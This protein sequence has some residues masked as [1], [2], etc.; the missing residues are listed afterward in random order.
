MRDWYI[1]IIPGMTQETNLKQKGPD[2]NLWNAT[3]M[4][5]NIDFSVFNSCMINY[6]IILFKAL[7]FVFVNLLYYH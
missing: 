3:Y 2:K 1:I 7:V 4:R 5:I 6:K